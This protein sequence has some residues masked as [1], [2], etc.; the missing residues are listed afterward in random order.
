MKKKKFF[1]ALKIYYRGP[2]TDHFDGKRFFNPWN[3]KLPRTRDL[4]RWK[5]MARAKPW[6]KRIKKIEKMDIPPRQ[7][8]GNGLRSCFVGHS[9]ILI[10]TQ[11]LNILTDPIWSRRA[12]PFKWFGPKR[13]SVPGIAFE[14]LPKIDLIL[15]SHNHYD[16]LDLKTI[17]RIWSRDHPRIIT[18]LGND[19]I[20]QSRYKAIPVE[21]LDWHQ[22]ISFNKNVTIHLEPVQH[23]SARG[24][25]DKNKAL[26]GAFV[27]ETRG[28]NIYFA[29]D[30]GYGDG[31]F[32][33]DTLKRFGGFRLALLPIGAYEP[34]WFMNYAHM[35]PE[36][37]VL[38]HKDLGEPYTAAIHFQTFKLGDEGHNDPKTVLIQSLRKHHVHKKK[39]RALD[40]GEVWIIPEN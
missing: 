16:H 39:F 30:T 35:N 3:P 4:I 14:H 34:K 36:E 28:G 37:A 20:I 19:T 33:R 9:T 38:A 6:P 24:I 10:Q 22:S 11:G 13:L 7:V 23:W 8:K 32:F 2:K 12:S 21:T 5:M 17:L 18:P 29:G 26:W 25:L 27:I 1:L 31:H 15:I 40:I